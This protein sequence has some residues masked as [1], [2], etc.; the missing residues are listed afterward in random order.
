MIFGQVQ[1][2]YVDDAAATQDEKERLRID[3]N[4]ID[5]V[6]RLGANEYVTFG[7]VITIPRPA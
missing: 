7:E 2:L 3:A 6:G 1:Q 5:A 4:A